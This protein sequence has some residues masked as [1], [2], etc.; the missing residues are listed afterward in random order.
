MGA[1]IL[2]TA[3]PFHQLILG[4]FLGIETDLR[5]YL[6]LAFAACAL[7]PFMYAASNLLRGWFSGAEQTHQLGRST[8][9]KSS[10]LLLLWW[11]LVTWQPAISGIALAIA[12]LVAA[13]MLEA[14]YLY[15]QRKNQPA[16]VRALAPY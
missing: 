15:R 10:F 11:P 9:I 14:G 8:L 16:T 2:L 7:F 6:R 1:I 4:R 3:G 5:D 13:E 12:L